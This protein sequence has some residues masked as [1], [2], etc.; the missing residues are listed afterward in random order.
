MCQQIQQNI[1]LDSLRLQILE[2]SDTEYFFN[3]YTGFKKKKDGIKN[4]QS[5]RDKPIKNYQVNL[6]YNQI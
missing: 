6:I 4:K 2:L 3:L 5:R 1:D